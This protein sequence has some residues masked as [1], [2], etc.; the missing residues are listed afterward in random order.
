MRPRIVFEGL[1]TDGRWSKVAE[2][3]EASLQQGCLVARIDSR[4]MFL[5]ATML[6]N[7]LVN[8]LVVS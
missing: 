1:K 4:I 5:N 3:P 7:Q 2:T 8:W 6:R